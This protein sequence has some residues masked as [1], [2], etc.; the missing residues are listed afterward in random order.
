MFLNLYDKLKRKINTST[1]QDINEFVKNNFLLITAIYVIGTIILLI[2]N[3]S[4]GLLFEPISFLQFAIIVTYYI[5]FLL[6]YFLISFVLKEI[7]S[8]FTF[9]KQT[10]F[11]ILSL[12]LILLLYL[13][14]L[15]LIF[16]DVKTSISCTLG[17]YLILPGVFMILNNDDVIAK[18]NRIILYSTILLNVPISLGGFCGQEVFFYNND[19]QETEKY[20]YYGNYNELYQFERD[21]K[22]YLFPLDN[23]YIYYEK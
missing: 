8:S 13:G 15:Y 11:D 22:I 7:K 5:I 23:G 6:M 12:L 21:N 14:L 1:Y 3:K 20:I 9:S 19:T 4:I 10:F 2:R 16:D 17:F 18:I